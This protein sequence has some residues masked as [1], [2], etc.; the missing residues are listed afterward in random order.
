MLG[1]DAS[2]YLLAGRGVAVARPFNLRWLLPTVCKTDLRRWYA[3]WVSSWVIA[4]AGMLWWGSDLGWERAGAAAVLLLAL[5]GV[6]GPQVVRP[7]GVDLPAMA[8]SIMAVACFEHGLWPVAIILILVAASIKE[9]APIF[10]AIWAWHP[11]MLVGLIVSAVVWLVRKPQLD[12]VT[13]QPL[14]R[15]VHEHPFKTALEAHNGRW[16]D[17]W[18]MVAPWGATLAALYHPSW[19][20]LLILLIA[21][22]Q[23]LVATDTVRLLH[24]AAG[25][26]MAIAAAQVLPVQWLPLILIAHFFWWRKPEVI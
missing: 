7:V 22:A 25:P 18:L 9:T 4:A 21:Y 1:P 11:I 20:T 14:L 23:L 15:R 10:A 8:V 13:A 5:P 12:Q 17:A 24:T 19:Q 6:W 16:R 2:R 26:V 3:V